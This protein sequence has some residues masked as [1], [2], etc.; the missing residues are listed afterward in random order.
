MRWL[1]MDTKI[2][3]LFSACFQ[4]RKSEYPITSLKFIKIEAP[5]STIICC[6]YLS[7]D[8]KCFPARREM[9]PGDYFRVTEANILK[10]WEV[11]IESAETVLG[12]GMNLNGVCQ[13]WKHKAGN[14][15]LNKFI[16]KL[17]LQIKL[18]KL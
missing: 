2:V 7:N 17:Y 9:S 1:H 11:L 8:V 15:T 5:I 12:V 16:F 14:F 13:A 18:I 6:I 3:L 4:G 10:Q